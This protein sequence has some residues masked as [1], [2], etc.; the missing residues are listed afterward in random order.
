MNNEK[1]VSFEFIGSTDEVDEI[2]LLPCAWAGNV[3]GEKRAYCCSDP[4]R[5]C[6]WQVVCYESSEICSQ[7]CGKMRMN[8]TKNTI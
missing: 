2:K 1:N 3:C 8:V 5:Y 6:P 7:K 4:G